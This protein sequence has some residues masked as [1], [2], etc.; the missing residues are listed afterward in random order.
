MKQ[1]IKVKIKRRQDNEIRKLDFKSFNVFCKPKGIEGTFF[2]TL[3]HFGGVV[4]VCC[5]SSETDSRKSL[6]F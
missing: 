3:T 1:L 5:T 2:I 4:I 6:T